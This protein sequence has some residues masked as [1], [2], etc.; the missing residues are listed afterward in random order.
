MLGATGNIG[1]TLSH[2]YHFPSS[3]GEDE[4]KQCSACDY[5]TNVEIS[6][7]DACDLC[8]SPM[9]ETKG[10]EVKY[11]KPKLFSKNNFWLIVRLVTLSSS[12]LNIPIF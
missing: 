11:P 8:G 12:E 10:I 2:E 9:K 7:K 1:G 6:D 4:L 5:G 3:I